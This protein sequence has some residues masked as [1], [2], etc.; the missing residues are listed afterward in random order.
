MLCITVSFVAL[1]GADDGL[2]A[3]QSPQRI[4]VDR[5]AIPPHALAWFTEQ[6]LSFE[7]EYPSIDVALSDAGIGTRPLT[8]VRDVPGLARNVIGVMAPAG[9]E[10]AYLAA[11]EIIVPLDSYMADD[12]F[13]ASELPANA[14][15]SAGFDGK[16]WGIPWCLDAVWLVCDTE[17]LEAAGI[18]SPPRTW[19]EFMDCARA[20][21]KDTD[22]DGKI[23]Q[24]G[25][26]APES[27]TGVIAALLMSLDRQHGVPYLN[28]GRVDLSSPALHENIRFVERLLNSGFVYFDPRYTFAGEKTDTIKC[29]M[30][31]MHNAAQWTNWAH[32]A[33]TDT[34]ANPGLQFAS[35]PTDGDNAAIVGERY[36]LCV[37]NGDAGARRASW[38]FLKWFV[39]PSAPLDGHWFGY[40]VNRRIV[41]NADFKQ[42]ANT[43]CRD[44][45]VAIQSMDYSRAPDLK[46]DL[47]TYEASAK[48]LADIFTK[49]V[50]IESGLAELET[51]L[52]EIRLTPAGPVR[53]DA[54]LE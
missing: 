38:E 51:R 48:A 22:G 16:T 3:A 29:G 27:G 44:A 10:I 14:L 45:H 39:R 18:A 26:R 21:T 8:H 36:Y 9:D 53:E 54:I 32:Q 24:F 33:A 12:A 35:L 34:Y 40:P 30:Q 47:H 4:E 46:F 7:R 6:V 28:E 11:R 52:N 49:S 20:L 2:Q 5:S 25:F 42:W 23:D 50:T 15:S 17:L 13:D 41:E 1:S 31:I 43:T 19:A 37:R